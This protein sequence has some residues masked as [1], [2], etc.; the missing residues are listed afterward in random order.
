MNLW[1]VLINRKDD[2]LRAT[3]EHIQISLIALVIAI[4][5]SIPVGLLLTRMPRLAA[6]VI[7]IASLFQTIPSLA[8]LGFM[9]PLLGI[10]FTPAIVALTVYA[11]LPILRNTYTGIM[12]VE[13]PIK[14]RASAWA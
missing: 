11:L 8:L 13:K 7:G 14:K 3:L 4:V 2:I 6:P 1:D 9:I 5:I 10:G 12:N